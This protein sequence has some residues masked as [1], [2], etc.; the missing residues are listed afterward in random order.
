MQI[1]QN[2]KR[3]RQE[4]NISQNQLARELNIT[5]QAVSKWENGQ[6]SP[7]IELL[8]KLA[9]FFAVS[10]DELF[11]TT[12]YERVKSIKDSID[13]CKGMDS[14]EFVETEEF[15]S[16]LLS[17]DAENADAL[18]TL[19]NLYIYYAKLLKEKAVALGKKAL[20]RDKDNIAAIHIINNGMDGENYDYK[21]EHHYWLARYFTDSLQKNH[22]ENVIPYLLDNLIADEKYEDAINLLP[23][24][25]K[26]KAADSY[27]FYS[28]ILKYYTKGADSVEDVLSR[29]EIIYANDPE[30]LYKIAYLWAKNRENVG[31]VRCW[32]KALRRMDNPRLIDPLEQIAACALLEGQSELARKT[33]LGIIDILRTDWNIESSEEIRTIKRYINELEKEEGEGP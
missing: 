9:K 16:K 13:D 25:R 18:V 29:L 24:L 20:L 30:T 3:L 21:D 14:K 5:P 1:A 22:N 33:Y 19:G 10:I 32:E 27:E 8:P 15:L 28:A 12:Q 4:R 7:D 31:A 26:S 17:A 11:E 23:I 2:I 6:A